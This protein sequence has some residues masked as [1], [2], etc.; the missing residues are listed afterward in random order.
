MLS[1]SSGG[2]DLPVLIFSSVPLAVSRALTRAE[3]G[4]RFT[5]TTE[6]A[7]SN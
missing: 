6:P 7:A 3:T 1:R 5:V 4:E 2:F